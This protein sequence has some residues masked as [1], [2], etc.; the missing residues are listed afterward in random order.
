MHAE[1][2]AADKPPAEPP[3]PDEPAWSAPK[4]RYGFAASVA[5]LTLAW[6]A[7]VP[8]GEPGLF[9]SSI[10]LVIG[11]IILLGTPAIILAG[12]NRR[13]PQT[14]ICAL[15]GASLPPVGALA[16]AL[17]A[18]PDDRLGMRQWRR[19]A[20]GRKAARQALGLSWRNVAELQ[21]AARQAGAKSG[22]SDISTA[23]G[24][25]AVAA[26]GNRRLEESRRQAEIRRKRIEELGE[27]ADGLRHESDR[28]QRESGQGPWMTVPVLLC[29]GGIVAVLVSIGMAILGK[30][31]AGATFL[32][33]LLVSFVTFVYLGTSTEKAHG[34]PPHPYKGRAWLWAVLIIGGGSIGSIAKENWDEYRREHADECYG[35]PAPPPMLL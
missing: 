29:F 28:L 26:A 1:M 18:D 19:E 24:L 17:T 8:A 12:G 4:W 13:R 20:D 5:V 23:D 30:E 27:R 6:V 16:W 2:N 10:L 35:Q 33:G 3:A 21:W 22:L 31:G 34:A 14:W 25:A 11:L 32:A 7:L 9:R 15:L